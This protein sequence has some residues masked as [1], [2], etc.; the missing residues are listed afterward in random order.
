MTIKASIYYDQS[1]TSTERIQAYGDHYIPDPQEVL[2]KTYAGTIWGDPI[3]VDFQNGDYEKADQAVADSGAR[4]VY[5]A[6]SSVEPYHAT[7]WVAEDD[8]EIAR[9]AVADV[10]VTVHQVKA[11]Y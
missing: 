3:R 11:F 9:K 8:S 6:V 5:R 10:G 7:I 4:V 1:K 2:D